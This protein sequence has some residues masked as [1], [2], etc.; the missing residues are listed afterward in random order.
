M[1]EADATSMETYAPVRVTARSTIFQVAS[2]GASDG[3]ELTTNLMMPS[4]MQMNLKEMIALRLTNH[5]IIQ[6]S[7]LGTR[8]FVVIGIALVLFLVAHEIMGERSLCLLRLVLHQRPVCLLNTT[9]TEHL[10]QPR[11]R[12][13][14]PGEDHHAADGTIQ[15]VHYAQKDSTRLG[16]LLLDISLHRLGERSVAGLVAL[17]DLT[18]TLRDDDDVVI[19]V[20]NFQF[21]I[22]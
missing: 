12:L 1:F 7:F 21:S 6:D 3:S 14:S 9:R 8:P 4:R 16:I 20:E 19:L 5:T 11:Q 17:H 15:P 10:I 2:D 13:A 22:S 18:R